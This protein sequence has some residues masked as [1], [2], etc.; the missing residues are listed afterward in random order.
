MNSCA[1]CFAGFA[2]EEGLIPRL[3]QCG[4][5]F[6]EGCL[7]RL[8]DTNQGSKD[9]GTILCAKC[10]YETP[11]PKGTG[12]KFLPRNF[13]LLEL[14]SKEKTEG[15]SSSKSGT[16]KTRS[17]VI[18]TDIRFQPNQRTEACNYIDSTGDV[19]TLKKTNEN[20]EARDP[21]TFM[22]GNNLVR[23]EPT[24]PLPF[25]VVQPS[26]GGILDRC[27]RSAFRAT[28]S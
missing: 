12:A 1:I 20:E 7:Q 5:S 25:A 13:D 8:A 18:E 10:R 21:F 24:T 23:F 19:V 15:T 6:C 2:E 26:W 17:K 3:L 27:A 11:L 28:K 16:S 9:Q 22:F 14:L 4:H